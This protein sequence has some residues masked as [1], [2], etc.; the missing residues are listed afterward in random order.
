LRNR[1][2]Y[3]HRLLHGIQ[4]I[5][6]SLFAPIHADLL[7]TIPGNN[8]FPARSIFYSSTQTMCC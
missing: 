8:Y 6:L 5:L 4:T 2:L 3:L 1:S 7:Y